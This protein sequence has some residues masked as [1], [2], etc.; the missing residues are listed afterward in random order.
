[1]W[2]NRGNG[3]R[4]GGDSEIPI[5]E[6]NYWSERSADGT[7][8]T[9]HRTGDLDGGVVPAHRTAIMSI[10]VMAST[11]DG[12]YSTVAD[13]SA[14]QSPSRIDVSLWTASWA[15]SSPSRAFF[16]STAST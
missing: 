3:E 8:F 7:D 15:I 12:V 13:S 1:M 10:S 11:A 5:R 6:V 9:V 16:C 4:R 14:F 2:I